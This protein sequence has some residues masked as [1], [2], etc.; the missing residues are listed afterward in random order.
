MSRARSMAVTWTALL[1]LP[2]PA[3]ARETR[4]VEHV[5]P[6]AMTFRPRP[7]DPGVHVAILYGSPAESGHYVLRLRLAAHWA[8]RPHTHGGA[9]LLTVHSGTCAMAHGDDLSREAAR[10]L[11]VGS[12]M[13]LSAGTPM[14]AFA[15]AEGCV[16][17][18]Q[19]QGPLTT[20][21]LDEDGEPET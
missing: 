3:Q 14:R 20:R 18:V 7:E 1:L 11:P 13:A 6:D 17:D 12:F 21:Y 5:A 9:E 2:L 15:G 8:G 16:V 4:G 19:G 10:E